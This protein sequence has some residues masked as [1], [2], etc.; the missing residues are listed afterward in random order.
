MADDEVAA[1]PNVAELD[2][3]TFVVEDEDEGAEVDAAELEYVDELPDDVARE[4]AVAAEDIVHGTVT[5]VD[6]A[7]VTVSYKLEDGTE[8][9]VRLA[10]CKTFYWCSFWTTGHIAHGKIVTV[11]KRDSKH[12]RSV[13]RQIPRAPVYVM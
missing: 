11:T 7:G 4:I 5:R 2:G 1:D 8:V 9:E 13:T 3:M 6:K 12:E 10:A